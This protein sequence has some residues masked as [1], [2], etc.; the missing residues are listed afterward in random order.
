MAEKDLRPTRHLLTIRY[1]IEFITS[2]FEQNPISQLTVLSM[3]DGL[4]HTVSPM[5][6]NPQ[7][8]ITALQKLRSQNPKGNP[9]LQNSLDMARGALFHSPSHGTRE[10]IVIYGAIYSADPGDIHRT[11]RQLVNDSIRC[12]V[13]GLAARVAI[14]TELVAKTNNTAKDD[15]S[16]YGVALHE[17]NFRALLMQYITPPAMHQSSTAGQTSAS[18]S[19]Q[20]G[21][22]IPSLLKMGL[23]NLHSSEKATMCACH[24]SPTKTG[25]LCP[26]CQVKVCS[27]PAQCPGCGM[28][29][30]QSTHLARS[31]HHLFPLRNFMEV[32]W[33]D[34]RRMKRAGER[35]RKTC[36]SCAV[37]HFPEPLADTVPHGDHEMGDGAGDMLSGERNGITD[38]GSTAARRRQ[39]KGNTKKPP[40]E[41]RMLAGY[42]ETHRYRCENCN[43]HYCIHCDVLFHDVLHNC[44]GCLGKL[45]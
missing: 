12:S 10:V 22:N 43:E 13:V 26:Q 17:Q 15:M 28:Q 36:A 4:S 30:I 5:S 20:H 1:T 19:Q 21:A 16:N 6:G 3:R 27:V 33:A 34:L 31:Y 40:T 32:S 24:G 41:R 38:G 29:L 11:I 44:P 25:Y 8:H 18:Q 14:C 39:S 9:S 23:P 42:S 2:F 35:V 45:D 37:T 7:A